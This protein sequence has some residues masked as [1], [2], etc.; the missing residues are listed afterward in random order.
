MKNVSVG[1][2]PEISIYAVTL[3]SVH[4]VTQLWVM[5]IIGPEEDLATL[6]PE[7]PQFS[8]PDKV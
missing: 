7:L 2:F 3:A 5:C 1:T 6:H 4:D 8:A